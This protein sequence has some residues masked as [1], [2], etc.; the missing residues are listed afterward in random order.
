ML[1]LDFPM[2]QLVYYYFRKWTAKGL[3][4]EIHD[5][6]RDKLRKEKGK[7]VSPSLGL[8]DSETVKTLSLS[9]SNGYDEKQDD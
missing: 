8:I 9:L 2:W 5:F 3:I 7:H 1:P 6:L 4:E